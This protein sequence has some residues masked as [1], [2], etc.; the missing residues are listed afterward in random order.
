MAENSLVGIAF[1]DDCIIMHGNFYS[2]YKHF[3]WI[4]SSFRAKIENQS[5]IYV[6]ID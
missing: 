3:K 4:T 1:S 6:N 2:N 5:H